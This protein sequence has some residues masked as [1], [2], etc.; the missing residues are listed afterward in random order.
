M[1]ISPIYLAGVLDADGSFTI[2]KRN[3]ND[4]IVGFQYSIMVQLTWKESPK[5]VEFM[6]ELVEQYGGGVCRTEGTGYSG[7]S[8]SLKYATSSYSQSKRVIESVLPYLRLKS[9]QARICLSFIEH[10]CKEKYTA[11]N[12]R[13]AEDWEVLDGF[14][15][16]IRLL[17]SKNGKGRGASTRLGQKHKSTV[18]LTVDGATKSIQDWSSISGTPYYRILQRHRRGWSDFDSIYAGQYSRNRKRGA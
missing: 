10:A 2:A 11:H 3:R 14:Y 17:N 7:K 16:A 12:R 9:E 13:S 18:F 8:I 5:S 15:N 4:S 1:Q 6:N